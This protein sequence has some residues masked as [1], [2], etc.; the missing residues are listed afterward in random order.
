VHFGRGV[1]LAGID[2][3]VFFHSCHE[4][5]ASI[6]VFWAFELGWR[7][8]TTRSFSILGPEFEASIGA[9]VS[10]ELGWRVSTTRSFF[11]F[12]KSSRR[13]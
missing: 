3:S 8:S 13:R 6:D 9:F 1:R 2:N 5:E 12:V 10:G 11:I 4:F 7:V